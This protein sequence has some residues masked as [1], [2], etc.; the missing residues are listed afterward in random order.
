MTTDK[1][2][3]ICG[4]I[5][6]VMTDIAKTGILK[7]SRAKDYAYRGIDAAMNSLSPLL[8]KHRIVVLAQYID[9]TTEMIDRT[10]VNNGER[11]VVGFTR[12]ARVTC[13][14]Q[15]IHADDG[16]KLAGRYY[17]EAADTYDK[18]MIKAQSVAFRTALFQTFVVPTLAQDIEEDDHADDELIN[19]ATEVAAQGLEAYGAFWSTLT[20]EDR[21][22]LADMH[23]DLKRQAQA[24]DA[25]KVAA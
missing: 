3:L 22:S 25:A 7:S 5:V 12:I 11:V 8:I 24:A 18:A 2:G 9:A 4:A 21:K 17:G 14:V 10:A 23:S 1:Q 19:R 13:A 16:S 20:R 6:A 15:F